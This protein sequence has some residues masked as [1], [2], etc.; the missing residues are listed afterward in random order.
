MEEDHGLLNGAT[1]PKP[2]AVPTS[3]TDSILTPK[4]LSVPTISADP[5]LM[6]KNLSVDS[7][8]PA[9]L[10]ENAH[11]RSSKWDRKS[12]TSIEREAAEG[13]ETDVQNPDANKK[14]QSPPPPSAVVQNMDDWMNSGKFADLDRRIE[15]IR[16]ST[17][18]SANREIDVPW[19]SH[20]TNNAE[21]AAQNDLLTPQQSVQKQVIGS[22]LLSTLQHVK[23]VLCLGLVRSKV[24]SIR[25][26][27]ILTSTLLLLSLF[28]N[29]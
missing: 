19:S 23:R 1:E 6:P 3:S 8:S 4:N 29:E 15:N 10:K 20:R 13:Q 24:R 26:F 11:K 14:A 9:T 21:L 25:L 2:T 17:S 27:P 12:S 22:S 16:Q 18:P 7:L 28:L 5:V